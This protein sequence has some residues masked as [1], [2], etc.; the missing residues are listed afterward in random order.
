MPRIND[1][2]LAALYSSLEAEKRSNP[3]ARIGDSQVLKVLAEVGDRWGSSMPQTLQALSRPGITRAE[4]VE[5][6]KRG[7]TASEKADL[8]TILDSST[9]A[10]APDAKNFVEAVLGRTSVQ[11]GAA[12]VISGDQRN[13]LSGTTWAGAKIEAM[14]STTAPTGRFHLE[15]TME[16][17]VADAQGKFFG[18]RLP[19]MQQG[20]LVR[21]RA[22]KSDGTTSDW[23]T[24]KATGIA[25][26]DTRNAE[27]AL[28]RIGLTP[29]FGG[30]I[31]V[32][33]INESRQIS[34]EGAR[35][36]FTNDRTGKKSVVTIDATGNF[37]KGFTLEGKKGDTLSVA[38]SDGANNVDFA[39]SLGKLTVPG[40]GGAGIDLVPDPLP[41]KDEL[42]DDGNSRFEKKQFS[43][44]IYIGTPRPEIVDQGQIGDC[45]FPGSLAAV[46]SALPEEAK[47]MVRDNG[48]GTYTVTFK[49]RDWSTPSTFKDVPI[50][51]DG[52]LYVRSWGGPLYGSGG[53]DRGEKTMELWFPLLE[54]AYATWKGSYDSIG[55]GGRAHEVFREVL[56]RD[57]TLMSLNPGG[58]E[59]AWQVLKSAVDEKRP[60]AAAT[61]GDDEGARY[62]NTGVY[63]D[64]VYSVLGYEVKNNERYVKLRNPWGE[65]EPHGNGPNDGVFL[66]KLKDFTKLYATLSFV[67]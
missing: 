43:G 65:S 62:T 52:D 35:L 1:R 25:A 18:A 34:E 6:V 4:Q 67:E 53:K 59:L 24:V 2:R 47:R 41:H 38:V 21:V 10:F 42:D 29:K 58:E 17:G 27:V 45:Y 36:Q 3:D 66:L 50:T 46:A 20:D 30:K 40:E 33:N 54:K 48:D 51:V 60:A 64:H 11:P 26:A 16:I 39:V 31:E 56:G 7:M 55:N 23:L 37:P 32:T 28:F 61:H 44:P 5:L 22:R 14:N 57:A 49:E 12:L 9:V 8:A 13:G 19:D 15:D 63:S